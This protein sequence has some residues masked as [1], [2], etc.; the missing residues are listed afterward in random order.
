[1]QEYNKCNVMSI[2]R[3]GVLKL[4]CKYGCMCYEYIHVYMY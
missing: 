1:M 4:L 3:K 2:Q